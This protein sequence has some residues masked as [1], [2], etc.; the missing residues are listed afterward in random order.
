[1][2]NLPSPVT[3]GCI[4]GCSIF[5]Q[6][7]LSNSFTLSICHGFDVAVSQASKAFTFVHHKLDVTSHHTPRSHQ[8][9]K[10]EFTVLCIQ[11]AATGKAT[12]PKPMG[13]S[14][15]QSR[16]S[17]CEIPS[18]FAC[19]LR[20]HAQSQGTAVWHYLFVSLANRGRCIRQYTQGHKK[21]WAINGCDSFVQT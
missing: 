7:Q 21:I 3:F 5:I 13:S 6:K 2:N 18:V 15:L 9:R 17:S 4:H 10:N 11:H 19:L 1:M 14:D 16:L 8:V 12:I 20:P